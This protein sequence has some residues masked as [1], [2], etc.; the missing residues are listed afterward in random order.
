MAALGKILLYAGVAVLAFV[1]FLI[2]YL[3]FMAIRGRRRETRWQDATPATRDQHTIHDH[4]V[5]S[6]LR[7]PNW[8]EYKQRL[9]EPPT[10]ILN[11]FADTDLVLSQDF[12]FKLTASSGGPQYW[13]IHRFIPPSESFT[14]PYY[15]EQLTQ[16]AFLFAIDGMGNSY[17]IRP[18]DFCHEEGPVYFYDHERGQESVIAKTLTAFIS[19]ERVITA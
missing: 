2:G 1:L 13:T 5:A 12:A 19:A 16:D 8:A 7:A 18:S 10:A 11:L 9:G 17:F 14:S 6:A 3:C 4:Q 15:A